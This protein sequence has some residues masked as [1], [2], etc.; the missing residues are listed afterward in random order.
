MK[1]DD[2]ALILYIEPEPYT[3]A[4]PV[5]D[6]L[7]RKMCAAFR[8][9][10]DAGVYWRGVHSC[11]CG[12]NSTNCDYILPGGSRTNSLCVHYLAFHRDDV[13][14][15]ELAKV[16]ALTSGDAEPGAEELARPAKRRIS[17]YEQLLSGSIKPV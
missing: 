14:E 13:P 6:D 12:V 2:E 5:I 17:R 16:A 4:E 1:S 8:A 9:A 15:T 3:S 10:E 11:R 7:T